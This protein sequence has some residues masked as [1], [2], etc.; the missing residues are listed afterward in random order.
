MKLLRI[1]ILIIGG[2]G[3]SGCSTTKYRQY[4][5]GLELESPCISVKLTEKERDHV[6]PEPIDKNNLT[7]SE[8]IIDAVGRKIDG[9]HQ[10]CDKN[11]NKNSVILLKHNELH[12]DK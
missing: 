8:L 1:L 5:V 7:E 10:T 12:Q 9:S 4:H 6:F 3:F 11:N 2:I